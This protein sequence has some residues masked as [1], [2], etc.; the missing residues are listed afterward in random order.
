MEAAFEAL[1]TYNSGSGRATLMPIDEAVR[2]SLGEPV[3]QRELER[4]LAAVLKSPVSS[5]AKEYICGKLGLVGSATSVPGLAELLISEELA[6]AA[7]TAL[8]MMPCPEAGQ[9][10]LKCLP[11]V[12][13]RQKTGVVNSLGMRRE[14]RSVPALAML[15]K[16]PDPRVVGAAAA[17]LG[18]IGTVT[19]ARALQKFLPKAA[20]V[21]QPAVADACLACAERLL[22]DGQKAEA[23][24]LYRALAETGQTK[25]VQQAANR[26]LALLA[27]SK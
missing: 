27:R 22:A 7:R 5:V 4:R 14:I 3:K 18:N 11:K 25:Q 12:G 23:L 1:K 15:L 16:D 24:A 20:R 17:A 10:L 19:A 2:A 8:E 13:G 26:G 9:A 6:D 21:V